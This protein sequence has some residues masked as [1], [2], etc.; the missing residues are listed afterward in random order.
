MSKFYTYISTSNG[1]KGILKDR[2]FLI[3]KTNDKNIVEITGHF[4][5]NGNLQRIA[6]AKFKTKEINKYFEIIK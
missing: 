6:N 5:I 4:E 2:I 3:R 1:P